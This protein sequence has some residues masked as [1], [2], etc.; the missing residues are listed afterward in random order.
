MQPGQV[1]VF[2]VNTNR[3]VEIGL[4]AVNA[5]TKY[6]IDGGTD[7]TITS[8]TDMF[9]S[10][11]SRTVTIKN[12]GSGILGI[13]KLKICDEV[14]LNVLSD[15]DIDVAVAALNSE[16]VDEPETT[17]SDATLNI[18]VVDYSGAELASTSLTATGAEGEE[19]V[20]AAADILEAA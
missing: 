13:T 6:S 16:N 3:Q 11:S 4:K 8:S 2:S 9:Y 12:T 10:I 7:T 17:Y 14:T 15:D 1:L 18:S 20:F 19:N 5:D